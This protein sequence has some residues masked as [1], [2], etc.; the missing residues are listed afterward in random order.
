[1]SLHYKPFGLVLFLMNYME[2][3]MFHKFSY[4]DDSIFY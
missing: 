2:D 3:L 4:V 1:M